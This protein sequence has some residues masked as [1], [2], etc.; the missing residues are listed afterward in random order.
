MN[1]SYTSSFSVDT[2]GVIIKKDSTPDNGVIPNSISVRAINIIPDKVA[3]AFPDYWVRGIHEDSEW[4]KV[5]KGTPS[6]S[7]E[8]LGDDSSLYFYV[9]SD[10]GSITMNLHVKGQI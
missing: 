5:D 6:Y 9:K 2:N 10:S 7:I 8:G 3:G 1:L 4:V